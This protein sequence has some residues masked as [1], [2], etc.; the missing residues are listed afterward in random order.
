[1]YI[2]ERFVDLL[3]EYVL[4]AIQSEWQP[5]ESL[6]SERFVEWCVVGTFFVQLKGALYRIWY[7]VNRLGDSGVKVV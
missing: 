7:G 5:R 1:M 6:S 3:F 4:G 2:V